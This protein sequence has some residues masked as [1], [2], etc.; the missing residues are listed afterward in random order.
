MPT[1]QPPEAQTASIY[2]YHYY[3]DRM[4]I[5]ARSLSDHLAMEACNEGGYSDKH[6]AMQWHDTYL[7]RLECSKLI[8]FGAVINHPDFWTGDP[9]SES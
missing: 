4:Q 8:T 3:H 7:I 9:G 1:N 6:G 2:Q 5:R